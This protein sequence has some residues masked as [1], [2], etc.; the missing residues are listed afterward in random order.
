MNRKTAVMGLYIALA[1]VFSYVEFLLPL[2]I[3]I[4]GVKIGFANI[5]TMIALY[6]Y[7]KKEAFW[8]LVVRI[9]LSGFMFSGFH[10]M[11]YA[12]AGGLCSLFIMILLKSS[13][14]FS[15]MG[16]SMAG[17]VCHNVAQLLIAAL[18]MENKNLFYY[19]PVLVFNGIAAGCIIG[20]LG[21]II[22]KRIK[23]VLE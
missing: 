11:M 6:Q 7:E 13:K 20:L 9:V 5:V 4:P 23:G 3:A 17:G 15:V 21:A 16:V 19:F 22:M 1:L 2:P 12:L 10:M 14:H 8:I 18:I